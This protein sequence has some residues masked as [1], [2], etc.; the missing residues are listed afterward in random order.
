MEKLRLLQDISVPFLAWVYFPLAMFHDTVIGGH[1]TGLKIS[2]C[3][4]A[5]DQL[6]RQRVT[7]GQ[8]GKKVKSLFNNVSSFTNLRCMVLRVISV[9]DMV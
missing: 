8:P 9:C 6:K 5:I 3:L 4:G 7:Y 2:S 1:L